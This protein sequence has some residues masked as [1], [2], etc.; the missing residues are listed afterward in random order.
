MQVYEWLISK[1]GLALDPSEVVIA[2]DSAGGNLAT[3]LM[4]KIKE[5]ELPKPL[6]GIIS[7]HSLDFP[8]IQI[9]FFSL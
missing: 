5:K 4:L 8:L 2:G 9:L 1:E 6:C 3:A 7:F